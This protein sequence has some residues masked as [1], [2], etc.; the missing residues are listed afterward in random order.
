MQNS[1]SPFI[2]IGF[3]SLNILSFSQDMPE[4]FCLAY[5]KIHEFYLRFAFFVEQIEIAHHYKI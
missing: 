2:L 5:K 3:A 4:Y 1:Q